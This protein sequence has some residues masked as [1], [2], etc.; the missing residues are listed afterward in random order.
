MKVF[1]SWSGKTSGKIAE[2]LRDWIPVVLQAVKPF[3]SPEDIG[4]GLDWFNEI[5]LKLEESQ[6][7]IMCLTKENIKSP[8]MLF[9]AGAISKN[10]DKANVCPILFDLDPSDVDGPLAQFM[11]STFNKEDFK[12]FIN[13][14]NNKLDDKLPPKVLDTVY[15]NFWPQLE[16]EINKILSETNPSSYR[17]RNEKEILEEL[18]TLT[19]KL[20]FS[21]NK[22]GIDPIIV[23]DLITNIG[24]VL[25]IIDKK[26]LSRIDSIFQKIRFS[27]EYLITQVYDTEQKRMLSEKYS[28]LFT[29]A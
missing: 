21:Q 20:A 7:G 23:S 26:Q 29:Q 28:L 11:F 27:I 2:K 17:T 14:M 24:E 22:L 19:R 4:K 6:F 13:T 9:E 1:I 16:N 10:F 18:L 12:R 25:K 8:W 5:S 15:D 3:Y